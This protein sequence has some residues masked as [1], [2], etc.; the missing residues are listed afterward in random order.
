M[1]LSVIIPAYN[2]EKRIL[3]SIKN[4]KKVF[5]EIGLN[6]ELIVVDDGSTDNTF[7]IVNSEKFE[8]VK[9]VGYKHNKGKGY[10]VKYGAKFI[11]KDLVTFLDADTDIDPKQIYIL[12]DYMKKYDADVVIGSKRH[13]QTKVEYYPFLRKILSK[14][15]NS[16]LRVLLGIRVKDTQAG[17]KLVKKNVLQDVFPL[18][19]VKRYAFDVE[20]L[21]YAT[22]LGY[23]I[24]EAPI[25]LN[26]SRGSFGRI[27]IKDILNMFV[28]TM[29]VA[30]RFQVL[31]HY[32]RV[33]TDTGIMVSVFIAMLFLYKKFINPYIFPTVEFKALIVLLTIC[34]LLIALNIPYEAFA[35]RFE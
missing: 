3:D 32:S 25:V 17:F 12:F 35:R 1:E 8:N 28:D 5:D 29:A 7:N 14:A 34:I 26:F 2:E 6:Y 23:K 9:I 15:Y 22:K 31:Q 27:K 30:Y 16:L 33:F 11:S 19:R 21:A 13:A 10:A 20:F 18:M 4:I 24:V